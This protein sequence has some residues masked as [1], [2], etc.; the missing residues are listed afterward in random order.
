[1]CVYAREREEE[2]EREREKKTDG[3]KKQGKLE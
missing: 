1:M 2:R 3:I